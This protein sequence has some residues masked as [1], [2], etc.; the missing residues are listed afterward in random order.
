MSRPSAHLDRKLI[1]AARELLPETG[2][3]GLS[4]REVARRAG[5]NLGMFHYHFKSK[6][7]FVHAVLADVYCDF[8]TSFQE[9]A[10]GPGTA[11]ERLRAVLV[12]Y[13]HFARRHRV[14]YA[15]MMRELLAGDPEMLSFAR[16]HFPKH[17]SAL[18]SLIER[19]RRDK[20]VRDLPTPM[21]CMF[22]MST[23]GV[24]SVAAT[25][26]E[27]CG[28]K[29]IGGFPVKDFIET[30]LSDRMI[31]TRAD[32]VLAALAPARGGKR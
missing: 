1:A 9:A 20:T 17:G 21:L 30:V 14:F 7:A 11:R 4:A 24:P 19:C 26:L 13:G 10:Q 12:A 29:K 32:M 2:L 6:R 8:L 5:V 27:R 31:E 28:Q 25:G 16:V 3:S 22:A 15:M 18:M 23:M